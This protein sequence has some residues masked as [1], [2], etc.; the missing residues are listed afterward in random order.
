MDKPRIAWD[1]T[2]I[3][4]AIQQDQTW[5]PQIRPIYADAL[6]G[7]VLIL[8]SEIS[9]AEA[10]KLSGPTTSGLSVTEAVKQIERFF[11]NLFILAK[12]VTRQE[13][14]LASEFIREHRLETCDAIIAATAVVH[15]A[16]TLYTRDGTKKRKKNKPSLLKCN[17]LLQGLVVECP[18]A[19][20]YSGPD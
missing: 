13:S 15:G 16:S 1:S 17:G 5:W 11:S 8:V 14:R 7:K 12:A 10:C 2:T 6:H 9:V 4:D 18:D 19:S 3:I 20:K